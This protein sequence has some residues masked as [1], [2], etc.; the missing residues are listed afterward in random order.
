MLHQLWNWLQRRISIKRQ[1][2]LLQ[3]GQGHTKQ[4][5]NLDPTTDRAQI[6]A[7][8]RRWVT[9]ELPRRAT[10]Y[11]RDAFAVGVALF[12]PQPS[13]PVLWHYL[14]PATR[15]RTLTATLDDLE[16]Q[17]LAVPDQLWH[18]A[19]AMDARL[20]AWGEVDTLAEDA[21]PLVP[22]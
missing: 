15:R 1:V 13:K 12:Q 2:R 20:I 11:G 14:T 17:V 9:A 18:A 5:W 21:T 22:R 10:P 7:D 6:I 8:L 3:A 4:R 16:H 19:T